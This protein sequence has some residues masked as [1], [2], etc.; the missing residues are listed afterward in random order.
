MS[1]EDYPVGFVL[2]S[3]ES[4][5][6]PQKQLKVILFDIG[7]VCVRDDLPPISANDLSPISSY[8][9]ISDNTPY[10]WLWQC[11]VFAALV[12]I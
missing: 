11:S 5:M 9:S 10:V 1:Q 6:A 12:V 7:G 3:L 4:I 8:L 2:E